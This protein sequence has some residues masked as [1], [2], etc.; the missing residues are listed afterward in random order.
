M[1]TL[2]VS[3]SEVRG[4]AFPAGGCTGYV[5][6]LKQIVDQRIESLTTFRGE[7]FPLL[8]P[9]LTMLLLLSQLILT[10][11]SRS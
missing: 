8:G 5:N 6:A 2:K 9:L 7:M 4:T 1:E 10:S 11:T 3:G